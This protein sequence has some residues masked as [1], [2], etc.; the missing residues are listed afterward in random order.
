M[1]EVGRE[2]VRERFLITRYLNDYIN[3]M[4]QVAGAPAQVEL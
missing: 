4:H 2:D 3:M 1:G